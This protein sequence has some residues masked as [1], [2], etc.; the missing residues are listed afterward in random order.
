[1]EQ[2]DATEHDDVQELWE[3]YWAS[4]GTEERNAIAEHYLSLVRFTAGRLA[5]GLPSHVDRDDLLSSGLFGLLDAIER[6]DATRKIK[7]E[8]YASV[9]IRGAMVDYLRAKDWMP[10]TARARLRKY[11]D[12]LY[13]LTND[14]GREPTEEE[15]QQDMGLNDK[16][17]RVL[18]SQIHM[19]TM[20]AIDDGNVADS[21]EASAPSPSAQ[22][23]AEELRATLAKAIDLIANGKVRIEGRKT[24]ILD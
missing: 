24:I 11:S 17:F 8:T 13:R 7:F 9:R 14:L 22:M 5:I 2:A 10:V 6:F 18:Q 3:A 21:L 1:M 12:A 4:H 20:V 15:I 23:E 16:E 19:A